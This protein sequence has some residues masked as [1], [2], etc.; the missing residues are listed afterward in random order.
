MSGGIA[1]VAVEFLLGVGRAVAKFHRKKS[2]AQQ[3]KIARWTKAHYFP[4]ADYVSQCF[5]CGRLRQDPTACDG[6]LF[7]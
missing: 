5:Y 6:R 1:A 7:V 3:A 2:K 4:D